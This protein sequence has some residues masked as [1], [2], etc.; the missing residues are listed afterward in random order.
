MDK[1]KKTKYYYFIED[2]DITD[3][4]IPDGVLVRQFKIN[5]QKQTYFYTK[6]SYITEGNLKKIIDDVVISDHPNKK[7]MKTILV[8]NLKMNKI[9]NKHVPF[10]EI[11]R[12]AIS[13]KSHFA[14]LIKSKNI[15]ICKLVNDL[16]KIVGT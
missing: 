6:N 10:D 1:T 14:D 16:K 9:R 2:L 15:D 8:S 4:K 12:V 3:D 5:K 13:K 7:L 11:P